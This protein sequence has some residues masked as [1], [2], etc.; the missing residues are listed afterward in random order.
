MKKDLLVVESVPSEE[1][2]EDE[3]VALLLLSVFLVFLV[4][5]LVISLELSSLLPLHQEH[6]FEDQDDPFDQQPS[7][8][9]L[10]LSDCPFSLSF[11]FHFEGPLCLLTKTF[12]YSLFFLLFVLLKKGEDEQ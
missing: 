2:E 12:F 5:L 8:L 1:E 3:E 10:P 9:S 6:L 7:L 4:L 11:S